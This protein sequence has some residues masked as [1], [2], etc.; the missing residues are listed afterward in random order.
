MACGSLFYYKPFQALWFRAGPGVGFTTEQLGN[1]TH[2]GETLS[3]N[4]EF[5]FRIGAGYAFNLSVFTLAPGIDLDIVREHTA[6]VVGF[7]VG[8]GI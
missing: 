2:H 3:H 1:G 8:Y 6:H 4:T 5:I 7:N